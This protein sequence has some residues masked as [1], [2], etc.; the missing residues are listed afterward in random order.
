M[1]MVA[2]SGITVTEASA[3]FFPTALAEPFRE[4]ALF[5]ESGSRG[6]ELIQQAVFLADQADDNVGSPADV[7]KHRIQAVRTYTP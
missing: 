2:G 1:V 3:P 7:S 6:L 5:E 4:A